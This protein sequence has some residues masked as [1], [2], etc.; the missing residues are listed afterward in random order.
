MS[1]TFSCIIN[2]TDS[3]AELGLEVWMDNY[4]ILNSQHVN[5]EIKINHEFKDSDGVHELKF[6]LKNKTDAHTRIDENGNIV[7]D[8][9]ITISQAAFDDIKLEHTFTEST[10]YSHN[11][12]GTQDLIIEP[13]YGVMGCNGTVSMQFT[14]PVY[15]W[16]LERM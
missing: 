2:T 6:I 13:F 11:F 9:C 8:A 10:Q 14:S 5:Q 16:L 15:L 1:T 7:N 3:L 4:C 12:N